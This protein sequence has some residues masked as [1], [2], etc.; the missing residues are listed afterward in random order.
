MDI[1]VDYLAADIPILD[2]LKTDVSLVPDNYIEP[3]KDLAGVLESKQHEKALYLVYAGDRIPG[4]EDARSASGD[5]QILSQR[6]MVVVAVRHAKGG[7]QD[8]A[9]AGKII[10]EV[11][12]ALSGWSPGD[13]YQEFIRVQGPPPFY[14][15]THAHYPLLFSTNLMT[16]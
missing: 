7:E 6:W 14:R 5:T 11:I 3:A 2:K 15:K 9:T 1:D 16:E 12:R 10:M 13:S 4:G 8:K